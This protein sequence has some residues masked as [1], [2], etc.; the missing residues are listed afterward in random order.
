MNNT[1]RQKILTYTPSIF[2]PFLLK[3]WY[4]MLTGKILDLRHPRTFNEKIQWLKI[5]DSTPLKT[6]LT[7]KYLV[8]EW[9]KEKI[10]EEYLIPLLGVWDKFDDIDFDK[11]PDKFIL[12]MNH[13]CTMHLI[14]NDKSNFDKIKAKEKF[15]EWM[16]TN[17]A[18]FYGYEL[19]Y[20]NIKPKIIA[21]EYIQQSSKDADLRLYD[22]KFFCFNGKFQFCYACV[23]NKDDGTSKISLFD[24]DWNKIPV[25]YGTHGPVMNEQKYKPLNY[26][27]MIELAEILCKDFYFARADLYEVDGKIYFGEMTFTP[28]SGMNRL[29]PEKYDLEFGQLMHLPI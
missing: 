1:L 6:K 17:Y 8:R 18:F 16:K 24:R 19:Q 7:D 10:G 15:D 27:K 22:Y 2:Y 26:D 28:G 23:D 12:K 3:K 13:G 21:E 11:L 5:Y 4:K 29:T 20:K 25:K 9:V 14:V